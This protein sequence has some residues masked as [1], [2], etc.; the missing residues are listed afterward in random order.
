MNGNRNWL[1]WQGSVDHPSTGPVNFKAVIQPAQHPAHIGADHPKYMPVG[2]RAEVVYFDLYDDEGQ[3]LQHPCMVADD[4][5][6]R[7]LIRKDYLRRKDED[8]AVLEAVAE[9]MLEV[10]A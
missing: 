6:V 5:A 8:D 4:E 2:K 9:R 1:P 10:V 7:E 3:E